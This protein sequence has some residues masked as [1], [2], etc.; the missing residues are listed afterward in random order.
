MTTVK[1]LLTYLQ[2]LPPETEVSVRVEKTGVW[3]CW[4]EMEDLNLDEYTGNVELL[5]FR[6]DSHKN[7]QYY[8]KC[9]LH[10]G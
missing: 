3:E 4:T 7:S 6:K 1:E 2:T 10:F 9:Y 5:D 8:G